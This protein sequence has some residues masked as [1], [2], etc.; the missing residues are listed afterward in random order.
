MTE[1]KKSKGLR[2]VGAGQTRVSLVDPEQVGLAYRGYNIVELAE[3]STFEEVAYILLYGKLPTESEL[4]EFKASLRRLRA[5]P[6]PVKQLLEQIPASA[7]PMDVLRTGCSLLG[8][9][10]PETDF[11]QQF[12]VAE[13]LLAIFPSILCY[14][15]HFAKNGKRIDTELPEESSIAGHF[16]HMLLGKEVP[17]LFKQAMDASLIL[18]A[19]HEFNASTFACRVCAS[20]LADMHSAIIAGIGTLRGPLHGGANE[21][22]MDMIESYIERFSSPEAAREG[23]LDS[24]AKKEKIMGFG[25]AIYKRADP[26][27][28]IVKFWVEQLV[29]Q[30]G[31]DRMRQLFAISEVIEKTMWTE[32]NLFPNVDFYTADLYHFMGIPTPLFTPLFVI[33]RTS[34]WSAHI[35]EQ[36]ADNRLI[37]PS[38][39]YVGEPLRTYVPMKAR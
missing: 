26:R 25:H 4:D 30:V 31:N 37:R 19:E 35:M 16:L 39:E 21:A 33:A 14:W 23:L 22:A 18:Y 13:E 36:R 12:D 9:L 34:G 1:E 20:T 32:K 10:G 11:N 24:L 6:A 38:A 5:L 27:H 17:D 3:Y 15:Y 7:H 2:G 28:A 29:K 8:T